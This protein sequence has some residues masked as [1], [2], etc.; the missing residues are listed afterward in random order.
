MKTFQRFFRY[1]VSYENIDKYVNL[2][3]KTLDPDDEGIVVTGV[4][5]ADCVD[6]YKTQNDQRMMIS[7]TD[8]I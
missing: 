2:V 6:M 1:R 5:N 7:D 8:K 3:L 4:F